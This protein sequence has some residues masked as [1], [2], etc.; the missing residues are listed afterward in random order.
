MSFLALL[1]EKQRERSMLEV[2]QQYM[3]LRDEKY[4]IINVD[5][6]SAVEITPQQEKSL[7]ETLEQHT[8]KKVRIRMA[9]DKALKGGLVVKVGDT[10]LDAS[11]KR[12]LELMREQFAHGH[13]MN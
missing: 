9:L 12:Q 4:G 11:I 13:V 5:V 1:T 10:V 8:K 7:S 3:A 6:A 2:I